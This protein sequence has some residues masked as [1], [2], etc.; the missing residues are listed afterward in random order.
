MLTVH[1]LESAFSDVECD[2]LLEEAGAAPASE[3]R[4]VGRERDHNIRRAELVWLDDAEGA[5]WVME[6]LIDLVRAANRAVFGFD[7]RE[8]AES[9]QLATYS[10]ETGGHFDWHADI[11]D[12]P[13]ARRRKLTLVVQLSEPASYAGGRL[14]VRPGLQVVEASRARGAAVVFPSFMLHRVTPVTR[15]RRASLT[16]WAHGPA[17]R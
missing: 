11:G 6:R 16:V 15:G 8:F 9:A 3:A 13:A 10:A 7:V 12:G 17:F 2:R 4:L 14:E 1:T 5:G